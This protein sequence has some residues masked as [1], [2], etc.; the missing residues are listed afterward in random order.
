MQTVTS[1]DAPG[2]RI[3]RATD[4][5]GPAAPANILLESIYLKLFKRLIDEL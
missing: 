5:P 4:V 2:F 1:N 3:Y